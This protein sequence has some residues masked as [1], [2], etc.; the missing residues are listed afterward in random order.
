MTMPVA[1]DPALAPTRARVDALEVVRG[2]AVLG[3]LP[4]DIGVMSAS[5][6]P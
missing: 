2:A 5:P 4:M 1:D 3:S 6:Q